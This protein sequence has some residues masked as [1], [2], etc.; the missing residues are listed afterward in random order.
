MIR[1]SGR[2]F[3]L[4]IEWK[5]YVHW[6]LSIVS[7]SLRCAEAVMK[8][9]WTPSQRSCDRGSGGCHFGSAG[10]MTHTQT[11]RYALKH[12]YA[13]RRQ[14]RAVARSLFHT[15]LDL[16]PGIGTNIQ[17]LF[18]FCYLLFPSLYLFKSGHSRHEIRG[19]KLH[20]RTHMRHIFMEAKLKFVNS[21]NS[22]LSFIIKPVIWQH[23]FRQ[24]HLIFEF[25]PAGPEL[26][27]KTKL[28]KRLVHHS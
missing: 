27:W 21:K 13:Q 1:S 10:R 17:Q 3:E 12:T 5:G 23:I 18:F 25:S 28:H 22:R 24:V 2:Q 16:P 8:S 9:S 14:Q 19:C 6:A 15:V 20:I 11:Q 26:K 7:L 4:L